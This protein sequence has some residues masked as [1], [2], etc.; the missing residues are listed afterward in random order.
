[1]GPI[2][3]EL[4]K[5][6]SDHATANL[7]GLCWMNAGSRN[8]YNSKHPIKAVEDLKG[9]KIRM[10]GNPVFVDSMNAMGGNGIAMGFDQLINALQTGVV[11]GAENNEPSYATGQHYRHAKFYSMTGHLMIPEILVF[12]K[13]TW[14]TLTKED[15]DLIMKLAKEAQQ[16]QRGLWYEMEKKSL[17]R[18]E[19]GRRPG[20]RGRRSQALPGCREIRVGQVWRPAHGTH[21]AYPGRKVT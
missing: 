8:V 13:R 16:E 5:K 17:A 3:D 6:L 7:I 11:D 1:M 20:Q 12:S 18:D 14:Q 21:P 19:G 2:G 4:L 15:Q 10:M 9:L